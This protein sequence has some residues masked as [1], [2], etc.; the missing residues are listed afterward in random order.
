LTVASIGS[1]VAAP[2]LSP[3]GLEALGRKVDR[4]TIPPLSPAVRRRKSE[5][6]GLTTEILAVGDFTPEAF[7]R[8]TIPP[9]RHPQSTAKDSRTADR[10][11]SHVRSGARMTSSRLAAGIDNLHDQS[12]A[13]RVSA[14]GGGVLASRVPAR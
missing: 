12:R 8:A 7:F 11:A 10:S 2:K 5:C 9:S 14:A 1:A 4:E 3:S 13:S 6:I